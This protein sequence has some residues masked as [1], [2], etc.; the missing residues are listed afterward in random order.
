MKNMDDK[1][2]QNNYEKSTKQS[3]ASS[4]TNKFISELL[5]N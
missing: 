3:F 1:F 5:I 2:E 4:I